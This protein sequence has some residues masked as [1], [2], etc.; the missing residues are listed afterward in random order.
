MEIGVLI[1]RSTTLHICF[2][3]L[4]SISLVFTKLDNSNFCSKISSPDLWNCS[5]HLDVSSARLLMAI[6]CNSW[7]K[8]CRKFVIYTLRNTRTSTYSCFLSLL[9]DYNFKFDSKTTLN[10]FKKKTLQKFDIFLSLKS[11]LIKI[12]NKIDKFI[13]EVNIWHFISK[14]LNMSAVLTFGSGLLSPVPTYSSKSESILARAWNKPEDN[15]TK[16]D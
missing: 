10:L 7:K 14:T 12:N 1:D 3:Y 13:Y 6:R 16:C 9:E 2:N 8:E 15:V 5:I 4:S 11:I